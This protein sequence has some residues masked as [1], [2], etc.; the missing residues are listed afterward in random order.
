MLVSSHSVDVLPPG[1]GKL[2]VVDAV[3]QKL[4]NGIQTLC[5]GDRGSW[6]GNDAAL[7][8]HWPSV[9]VD[10]VSGSIATCWNLAPSGVIGPDAALR[11]LRAISVV[12]G[13]GRL[14]TRDLWRSP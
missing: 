3:Q 9:S 7:L 14:N 13:I 11:Y 12:D 10:E 8:S 6:P 1:V 4:K 2:A 5:I